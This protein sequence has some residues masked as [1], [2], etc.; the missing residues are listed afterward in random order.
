MP[1]SSTSRIKLGRAQ[2]S[3]AF[4]LALA[5]DSGHLAKDLLRRP[6]TTGDGRQAFCRRYQSHERR[7]LWSLPPSFV[8][9]DESGRERYNTGGGELQMR[10]L[11][12]NRAYGSE[13]E[14][15]GGAIGIFV[16]WDAKRYNMTCSVLLCT[17]VLHLINTTSKRL[18]YTMSASTINSA[19]L[20][21]SHAVSDWQQAHSDLS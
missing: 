18:P 19:L 8:L 11:M 3:L 14:M 17:A 12:R 10:V 20:Q 9:I 4:H 7:V 6:R 5:F 2:A 1:C 16:F 13:L 15:G 21:Q